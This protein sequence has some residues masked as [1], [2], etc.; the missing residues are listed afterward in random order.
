MPSVVCINQVIN[1]SC[2][3][4]APHDMWAAKEDMRL[5]SSDTADKSGQP[6]KAATSVPSPLAPHRIH[7]LAS[8]TNSARFCIVALDA[9][10]G[11]AC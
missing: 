8:R 5:F 3:K 9:P 2:D 10:G 6:S 4:D 7:C 11:A 1:V